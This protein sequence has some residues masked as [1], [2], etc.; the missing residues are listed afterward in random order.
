MNKKIDDNSKKEL[1]LEETVSIKAM[2]KLK[3][4]NNAALG[5]WFGLGMV[6]LIGWSV[7]IPML[8]GI[9]L[10]IFLDQHYSSKG[11]PWTLSLLILGLIIGCF[12]AVL[13]ILKEYKAISKEQDVEQILEQNIKAKKECKNKVNK[14]GK[15]E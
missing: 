2:R 15:N 11:F 1:S 7:A 5:V 9:G 6:G 4:R 13:W 12:N 8:I 3:A 14:V 10:G